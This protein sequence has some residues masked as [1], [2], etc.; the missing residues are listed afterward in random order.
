MG[1]KR[2]DLTGKIFGQ[3]QIIDYSCSGK[4]GVAGKWRCLCSCGNYTHVSVQNLN[5]GHTKSCGCLAKKLSSERLTKRLTTHGMFGTSIYKI[6]ERIKACCNNPNA[7]GYK[8]YG[9]RGITLC[10]SWHEFENF[11]A[12]MGER[13]KNLSIERKNN[14]KGYFPE[15]CKWATQKE[16][17]R[18]K[19]TNHI[20]D[21]KCIAEWSEIL[22]IPYNTLYYRI[23]CGWDWEKIKNTPINLNM[24]RK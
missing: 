16:Q 1:G 6:W 13:P 24:S 4:A 17:G 10:K 21:G 14:N 19:R 9:G 12:D 11:F 22:N 20:I 3:L 2:K 23:S 5:K 18:N 15:N 7:V 8:H